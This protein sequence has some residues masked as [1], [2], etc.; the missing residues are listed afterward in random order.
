[1]LQ[2]YWGRCFQQC[3]WEPWRNSQP[4]CGN[5]RTLVPS[6]TCNFCLTET[7]ANNRHCGVE[8]T[9][10]TELC[11]RGVWVNTRVG[12]RALVHTNHQCTFVHAG[13]RRCMSVYTGVHLCT[14]A[15]TCERRHAPSWKLPSATSPFRS[16]IWWQLKCEVMLNQLKSVKI[17]TE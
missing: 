4:R 16:I 13:G 9:T 3:A 14:L 7:P 2:Q 6:S 12:W 5:T 10:G 8:R 15:C 1:M 17:A 11:S